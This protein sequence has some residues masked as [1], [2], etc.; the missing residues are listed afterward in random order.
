MGIHPSP[1]G[2]PIPLNRVDQEELDLG[3]ASGA[4]VVNALYSNSKITLTGNVTGITFANNPP[5]TV[6]TTLV[7]NVY[8]GGLGTYT[9]EWAGSGV[10]PQEG[11]GSIDYQPKLGIGSYTQFWLYWNKSVWTL[12]KVE[13]GTAM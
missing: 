6:V 9:F 1:Q 2:A 13:I 10:L 7:L 11:Y 4:L 5:N 12:L 8:Q 3:D